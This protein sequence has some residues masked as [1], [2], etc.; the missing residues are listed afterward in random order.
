MVFLGLVLSAC[1]AGSS[2]LQEYTDPA[3]SS[4]IRL[5]GSWHL[6][7]Q[8]ELGALAELPF[9]EDVQGVALPTQSVA[10]FDGAP[11]RNV[12]YLGTDLA[13]APYPIGATS[14]RL[15]GEEQRDLVSRFLLTQA[16]LPYAQLDE[17]RELQKEDF[18][19]GEGFD[20]TRRLVA[21]TAD[22]GQSAG[23]AYL[24]AVTDAE[25]RRMFTVIAGCSFDCFTE[26]Q[27][28]IE[29]VVDSWLVNTKG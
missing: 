22:D 24:I 28:D 26:F 29:Q 12:E 5:P 6:Y 2:S 15:I 27:N 11:G 17:F 18:S 7:E 16:V 23:V 20:G 14:V 25:D 13:L 8:S 1:S 9:V 21:Y 19:F 10:A 4:L 3:R